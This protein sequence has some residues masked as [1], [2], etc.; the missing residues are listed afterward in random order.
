MLRIHAYFVRALVHMVCI[1]CAYGVLMVCLW[2]TYGVL[3]VCI[4]CAY[5]VHMVCIWCAYGVHMVCVC[6]VCLSEGADE[7]GFNTREHA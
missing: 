4:W 1:W 5:G 7:P 2:C 3:M 6:S